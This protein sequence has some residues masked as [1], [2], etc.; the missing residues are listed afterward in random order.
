VDDV[1]TRYWHVD[2]ASF[3][4]DWNSGLVDWGRNHVQFHGRTIGDFGLLT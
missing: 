4:V 2:L 3:D 1:L